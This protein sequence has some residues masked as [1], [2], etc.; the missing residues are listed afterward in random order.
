MSL[1]DGDSSSEPVPH[2]SPADLS[3]CHSQDSDRETHNSG[4]D[5]GGGNVS[6]PIS[7]I[8]NLIMRLSILCPT[9]PPMGL[10]GLGGDLS[11]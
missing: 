5:T 10:G 4:H 9:T 2:E 11:Y 3:S 8:G 6:Q 7:D 1:L